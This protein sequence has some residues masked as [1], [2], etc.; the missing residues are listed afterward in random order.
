VRCCGQIAIS[1]Q[2]NGWLHDRLW[3]TFPV[4][5]AAAIASGYRITFVVLVARLAGELLTPQ[6]TK[7]SAVPQALQLLDFDFMLVLTNIK[8]VAG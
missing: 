1:V 3:H 7:S 5:C 8:Y 6:Q 2:I 4:R